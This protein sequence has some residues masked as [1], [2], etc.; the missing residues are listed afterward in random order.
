MDTL[1]D[2]FEYIKFTKLLE[3]FTDINPTGGIRHRIIGIKTNNIDKKSGLTEK[4]RA[5]LK[6]G[7][8]EFISQVQK[9]IDKE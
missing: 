9:V 3:N 1:Q 7:L 8:T 6:A 2:V 5:A 4:D